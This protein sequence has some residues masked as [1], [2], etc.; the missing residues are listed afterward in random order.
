MRG[1]VE[2]VCA[3]D[4]FLCCSLWLTKSST[5][6]LLGRSAFESFG[7]CVFDVLSLILG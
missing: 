1:D 4:V 3:V 7:Q 5:V 2:L 6:L